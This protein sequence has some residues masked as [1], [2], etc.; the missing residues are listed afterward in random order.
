MKIWILIVFSGLFFPAFLF[1]RES[2]DIVVM[3]NGDRITCEIKGLSQGV[4]LISPPYILNTIEVDWLQVARLESRQLFLVKTENGATYRGMLTTAE[5]PSGRPVQIQ[6]AETTERKVE[7]DQTKIVKMD[8]TS[9]KFWQRFNGD[10]NFGIL[11]SKG[12]E[13][14]QYSFSSLVA[15]PRERW[16]AEA[17]Y[18]STLSSST[19]A[20]AS[21]RNLLTL[22]GFHR[23]GSRNWFYSGLSN[24]LQS[25]E[26]GIALQTLLGGG[27]GQ[28]LTDTNRASVSLVGGA[29]W[30]NTNYRRSVLPQNTQ[31]VATAMVAANV[32]LYSFN[33]TSLSLTAS[34]FPAVSQPGRVFFITN[35]SYLIKLFKNRNLSWNI[36]FYGNW[37]NEPPPGLPGSDYGSSSGLTWSFGNR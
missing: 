29:A 4:L 15:Y 22:T 16:A 33:R 2:T 7:L 27:V 1:A 35:T 9:A 6:I 13:S 36:S 30:L 11:Y 31:N 20:S 3:K 21:T 10:V 8:M 25:S 12:N 19:G 5:T 34:V 23:M 28:F 26:Q 37:D 18:S 24:F 32:K 17:A 14:T